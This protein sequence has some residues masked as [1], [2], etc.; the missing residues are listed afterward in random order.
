MRTAS[1]TVGPFFLDALIHRGDEV[2]V[3]SGSEGEPIVVEGSV[4]D[5]EG[6]AVCDAVLE[7]VQA[8]AT[9]CYLKDD[10]DLRAGL[11]FTGFGRAATDATG[12][13]RFTTIYPGAVRARD[14]G[15]E[16]PH[17]NLMVF[18]RGLL[19][20]LVT[21]IYFAGDARNAHD[22]VL[23][24]VAEN[25]RSTLEAR[26]DDKGGASIWRFDVRLQ[27]KNETVFF[28]F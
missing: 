18:A 4:F 21:R 24:Q 7:I 15:S 11:R 14:G 8:D 22:A 5:A 23:A 13:F 2:L 19:K 3:E 1:Q 9:G 16:A 6:N 26:R 12:T 20:P 17:L 28:D 10:A 27:G 25:R